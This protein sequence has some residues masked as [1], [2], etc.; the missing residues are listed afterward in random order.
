MAEASFHVTRTGEPF[1][2]SLY[3]YFKQLEYDATPLTPELCGKYSKVLQAFGTIAELAA[4]YDDG[5]LAGTKGVGDK[6]LLSV[7]DLLRQSRP[8]AHAPVSKK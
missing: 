4:A 2:Y 6:C 3:T 5:R 7:K 1:D 8:P